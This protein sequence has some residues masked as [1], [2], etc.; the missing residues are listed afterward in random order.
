MHRRQ[1]HL[2]RG[3]GRHIRSHSAVRQSRAIKHR[4]QKNRS[5]QV[6]EPANEPQPDCTAPPDSPGNSSGCHYKIVS[7]EQFAARHHH[8]TERHAKRHAHQHLCIRRTLQQSADCKRQQD[9]KADKRTGQHRRQKIP[10][11]IPL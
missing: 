3:A 1:R 4:C 2:P 5:G 11:R 7:G 9:A 10:S 6:T 8:Q